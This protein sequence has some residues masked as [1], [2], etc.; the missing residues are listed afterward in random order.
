MTVTAQARRLLT[1]NEVA[2]ALS[3]TPWHVTRLVELEGLPSYDVG[4]GANRILRFDLEE[5][6]DWAAKRRE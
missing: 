5:V 1:R 3:V 4:T 6:M 2:E